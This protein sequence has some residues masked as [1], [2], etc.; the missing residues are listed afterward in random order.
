MYD[1]EY[2]KLQSL[3]N[4]KIQ[5]VKSEK[6]DLSARV[7]SLK[8]CVNQQI[9]ENEGEFHKISNIS[10]VFFLKVLLI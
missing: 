7:S 8:A 2:T 9:K 3:A 6:E 4:D 10:S 5:Q 1:M